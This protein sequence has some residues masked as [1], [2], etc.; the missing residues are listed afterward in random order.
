M[1]RLLDWLS[2]LPIW[3]AVGLFLG[4]PALLGLIGCFAYSLFFSNPVVNQV[5][6]AEPVVV[7]A[8]R[9]C[10]TAYG[11]CQSCQTDAQGNYSC[12]TMTFGSCPGRRRVRET[13]QE[14]LVER[15][16][17]EPKVETVVLSVEPV[18]TCE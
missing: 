7:E 9:S 13:R 18:T 15:K 11:P 12:A 1:T 14:M 10:S 8:E 3:A 17:G 4:G 16:K 2:D 5:P 6:V